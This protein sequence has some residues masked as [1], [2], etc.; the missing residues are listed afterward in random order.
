MIYYI[1]T[2]YTKCIY[3]WY[4]VYILYTIYIWYYIYILYLSDRVSKQSDLV[5]I[6]DTEGNLFW[7]FC[8]KAGYEWIGYINIKWLL[9]LGSKPCWTWVCRIFS[10]LL[11]QWEVEC[12]S[13]RWMNVFDRVSVPTMVGDIG[14]IVQL[15]DIPNAKVWWR[16]ACPSKIELKL[17]T[18]YF[19]KQNQQMRSVQAPRSLMIR[20]SHTDQHWLLSW[21]R[22][23]IIMTKIGYYHNPLWK[24]RSRPT[25]FWNT[26]VSGPCLPN[27]N[28][29][30]VASPM[31]G[32]FQVGT[33]RY[34]LGI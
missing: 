15:D 4:V 3:I 18:N 32:A 16:I 8:Q 2:I 12:C 25:W 24:I 11:W 14:D 9:K 26:W 19:A 5:V 13:T 7:V 6:V 23:G 22:W 33:C 17:K 1:Y 29:P 27:Q 30:N 20:G 31:S 21:P 28:I 34:V 10:S